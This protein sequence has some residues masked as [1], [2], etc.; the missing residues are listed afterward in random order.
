MTLML[1]RRI[2]VCTFCNGLNVVIHKK[3]VTRMEECGAGWCDS[4]T[5]S[6]T[7]NITIVTQQHEDPA[8]PG[9]ASTNKELIP[10][11]TF[12]APWI[13]VWSGAASRH[14]A[15]ARRAAA[16][17]SIPTLLPARPKISIAQ[18]QPGTWP[19]KLFGI[20]INWLGAQYLMWLATLCCL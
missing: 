5:G 10:T 6:V 11:L 2:P 15:R 9:P 19:S 7:D 4:V 17:P 12:Q 13:S 3:D 18:P 8:P 16:V 14:W 1:M 20:S